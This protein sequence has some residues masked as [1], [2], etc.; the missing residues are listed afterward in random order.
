MRLMDRF[1][2]KL[3]SPTASEFIGLRALLGWQNMGADSI[4]ASLQ[5]SLFHVTIFEH[6]KLVA[7]GRVVGDGVMY[8]YIQDVIVD[9]SYQKLGLGAVIMENIESYLSRVAKAGATIGLLAAQGKEAFYH[10]YDY[11]SR[12]NA[13]LGH[14]MCK[15]I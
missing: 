15:F 7:M 12:P 5:D 1:E 14:G 6:T 2:I 13:A 11:I 3:T 9:P 4:T 8:F 10:K